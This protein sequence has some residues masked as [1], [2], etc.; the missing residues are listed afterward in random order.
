MFYSIY[1]KV[2]KE[3]TYVKFDPT[4]H[5]DN[6]SKAGLWHN[7]NLFPQLAQ[8]SQYD[9]SNKLKLGSTY[10]NHLILDMFAKE[11]YGIIASSCVLALLLTLAGI[12]LGG[13]V[14]AFFYGLALFSILFTLYFFRDPKRV[15][16]E[17]AKNGHLLISPADGKIVV[18]EIVHEP[19]YLK[20]EARQISIFLSPLDVHVN[21]S[22]VKGLV[23][24]DQYVPGEY[25]VA[26]EPKASERN[27][28]SQ[29]GVLHPSGRK[30]LF[31][32]IAG[33]VA[34]RIEYHI[35]PG[36]HVEAGE[37]FGIVKF[38]SRMDIL[39]P[40]DVKVEVQMGQQVYAGTTIL[41][42]IP[43]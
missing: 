13:V 19:L 20:S 14:G 18:N 12:G 16:P 27:E 6:F 17:E 29:I 26:W 41:G 8:N 35:R 37:R 4:K 10:L 15:S 25:L 36:D 30:F 31:K 9:S 40:I 1:F 7:T 23:E 28:R 11:G 5:L 42:R 24:F 3:G 39:M 22:P 34:R 21:R 38:G 2:Q 33:F 32:Q 43:Q